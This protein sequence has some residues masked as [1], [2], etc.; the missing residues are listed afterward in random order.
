VHEIGVIRKDWRG[1]IRVALVYPNRYAVGMSNLGFQTVYA[2]MNDIDDVVCERAFLPENDTDEIRTIETK[3]RLSDVDL[4]AFSVSFEQ[5]Y[6]NILSILEKAKIPLRSC[7][8]DESHPMVIAGGVACFSNPEPI[9]PF[10]DCILIGEAEAMPL[11]YF[12]DLFAQYQEDRGKCLEMMAQEIS[13]V[14]VPA[15]APH[16]VRRAYLKDISQHSTSTVVLSKDTAFDNTFLIE[17]SRGCPHGCRFCSAGYIYR[18]PRFRTAD[19]IIEAME[20]GDSVTD[21]I[22]LVGAAVSDLPNIEMLCDYATEKHIRLSFSSLRADA[23]SPELVGVL[24]SSRVKTATIAPEAGSERMRKVIN[25]GI[26][27]EHILSG[28]E[29]LVSNDIPNLKL[30][31]MIG[32]PT[33]TDGDILEMVDLCKKIKAQFLAASRVKGHIGEITVSINSFVPKPFTPFQWAAMDD[34][35]V[36]K[37][38]INMIRNGLKGVANLKIQ[39]DDPKHAI[40]QA[41]LSRGDRNTADMLLQAHRNKGNWSKTLKEMSSYPKTGEL[42]YDEILPWEFI[43]HGIDKS[44]L[45]RE[46]ERAKAGKSSPAC[47]MKFDS[48]KLCGICG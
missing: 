19:H 21:R 46:Y 36:L 5:D 41:L 24:N 44:F 43:D 33:E 48:C 28:A 3:S 29:I 13:G 17:V 30:Y 25:K 31:F 27:E 34:A 6:L 45:L 42:S 8:R 22:G 18:P 4:I 16:Q 40:V 39:A 7:E 23:L 1:R 12:F 32:L 11:P 14:Y 47:S 20:I 37:K 38:K 15:F 10:M 35:V 26:T 2:L 9:A